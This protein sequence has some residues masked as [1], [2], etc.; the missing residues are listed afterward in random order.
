M[1]RATI[2]S[3]HNEINLISDGGSGSCSKLLC[4][5]D[6]A[7]KKTTSNVELFVPKSATARTNRG[8]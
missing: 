8:S 3:P 5:V 4:S 7:G 1:A 6:G 2:N